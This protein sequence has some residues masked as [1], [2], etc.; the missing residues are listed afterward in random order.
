LL[1][2]IVLKNTVNTI[3]KNI[4]KVMKKSIKKDYEKSIDKILLCIKT[5]V[6]RFENV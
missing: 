4:E 1:D 6:R 2:L 3:K 5:S